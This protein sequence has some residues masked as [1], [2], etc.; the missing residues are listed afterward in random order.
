MKNVVCTEHWFEGNEYEEKRHN[1][2]AE[3]NFTKLGQL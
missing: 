3:N 1:L 2:R